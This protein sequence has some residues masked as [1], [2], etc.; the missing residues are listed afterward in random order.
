MRYTNIDSSVDV[1][2]RLLVS[3]CH[4]VPFLCHLLL[5]CVTLRAGKRV[6]VMT[7][8]LEKFGDVGGCRSLT[9]LTCTTSEPRGPRVF[10]G[11]KVDLRRACACVGTQVQQDMDFVVRLS[12]NVQSVCRG[13]VNLMIILLPLKL[14]AVACHGLA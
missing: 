5:A 13:A 10:E 8:E 11:L 9:L 6:R 2:R 7:E 12:E 14:S 4:M 3:A 1:R